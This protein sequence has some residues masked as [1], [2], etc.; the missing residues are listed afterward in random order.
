MRAN[1]P[2]SSL[3]NRLFPRRFSSSPQPPNRRNFKPPVFR[4]FAAAAHKMAC[5]VLG[6]EIHILL[7]R[8]MRAGP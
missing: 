3:A 2:V 8:Q 6:G 1:S 5:R 7:Q 4:H